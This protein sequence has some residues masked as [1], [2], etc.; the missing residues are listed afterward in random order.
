MRGGFVGYAEFDLEIYDGTV[1]IKRARRADSQ[2][3][4]VDPET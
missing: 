4:L 2:L 3:K 1:T